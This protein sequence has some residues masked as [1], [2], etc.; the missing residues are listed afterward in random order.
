MTPEFVPFPK[1]ARL[2]RAITITEKID[3]TNAAVVVVRVQSSDGSDRYEVHAQSRKRIITPEQDN[4]GFARWVA[5]HADELADG[6]GEGHHFGE[7]YGLGIQRNYGLDHKRFAL[8]NTDRWGEE[9]PEC[10]H[11]VPI[12]CH[13]TADRL[14]AE[15]HTSL[16]MLRDAGSAASPGFMNPEGIVVFHHASHGLFKVTLDANDEHKWAA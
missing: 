8:F 3:G 2:Y 12:I 1:L 11:V 7:W 6:L 5:E 4:F 10:C 15:V 9:R 16:S 13:S 14:N